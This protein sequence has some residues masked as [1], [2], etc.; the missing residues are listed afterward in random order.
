MYRYTILSL[1]SYLLWFLFFF[2]SPVNH[3]FV[4]SDISVTL[5]KSDIEASATRQSIQEIEKWFSQQSK[6][7]IFTNT[8]RD[9]IFHISSGLDNQKLLTLIEEAEENLKIYIYD[10]P[11]SAGKVYE[12][13]LRCS[14]TYDITKQSPCIL[15]KSRNSIVS[16]FKA[17]YLLLEYFRSFEMSNDQRKFMITKD[18]KE[19]NIFLIDHQWLRIVND[20][21][22]E[23]WRSSVFTDHLIPIIHNVLYN[24]PFYNQSNGH[25]HFFLG[26]YDLG[27]WCKMLCDLKDERSELILLRNASYI[28]NYGMD[29]LSYRELG[30]Y[31][32]SPCHRPGIL[33]CLISSFILLIDL[34]ILGKD[35]VIPNLIHKKT[36]D[37]YHQ[38][39][40]SHL[41]FREFDSTFTCYIFSDAKKPFRRPL[42]NMYTMNKKDYIDYKTENYFF[43]LTPLGFP[44]KTAI[45]RGYFTYSPCGMGWR[46]T[47]EDDISSPMIIACWSQRQYEALAHYTIPILIT[48]GG[49]QAFERVFDWT[50][51]T[52]KM[53]AERW[54]NREQQIPFRQY[55][56]IVTDDFR[57]KLRE[58]W[59]STG[60][61]NKMNDWLSSSSSPCIDLRNNIIWKKS[62]AAHQVLE[63]FDFHDVSLTKEKHAFRVLALELWCSVIQRN[64]KGVTSSNIS[65]LMKETCNR[66]V[67]YASR[68]E[69]F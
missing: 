45:Y 55:L 6:S 48:D 60:S 28:G 15:G 10:I 20:H 2:S 21:C 25:D 39:N 56:R 22:P 52:M 40:N 3:T 63:W 54:F 33:Y 68:L 1:F 9:S 53:S 66:R 13:D 38:Y 5:K 51:F 35:I 18:A 24:F 17:E 50:T 30:G 64:G 4:M 46:L 32:R 31:S 57:M 7:T 14:K 12:D 67:D 23:P 49:I 44:D 26:L 34:I 8:T 62:M 29:E 59:E 65:R 42:R 16:H 58:C 11:I 61:S 69:Y 36:W 47:R 37:F 41:P 19:A 43:N 27:P